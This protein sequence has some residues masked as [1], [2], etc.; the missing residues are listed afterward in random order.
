LNSLDD[1]VIA[2]DSLNGFKN[3]LN[4]FLHGRGFMFGRRLPYF[5]VLTFCEW[6][7]NRLCS[8]FCL[9]L[10]GTLA[11][12]RLLVPRIVEIKQMRHVK[13]DLRLTISSYKNYVDVDVLDKR[14]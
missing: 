3:R 9:L 6:T 4:K 11:I 7:L 8:V 12:F 14:K 10:N 5:T 13:N 1:N 2:C